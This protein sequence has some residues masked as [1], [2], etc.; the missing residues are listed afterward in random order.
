[1]IFSLLFSSPILHDNVHRNI[2]LYV[3]GSIMY[4][5]IHWI[6]FSSN[7]QK[8]GKYKYLLY[9]LVAC[10]I[11][12]LSRLLSKQKNNR[13]N[14]NIQQTQHTQLQPPQH[15]Q[16]QQTQPQQTQPQQTQPAQL[17][18]SQQ[19]I[20]LQPPQ[21]I[22]DNLSVA[23]I[24]VYVSHEH[25]PQQNRQPSQS[26]HEPLQQPSQSLQPPQEDPVQTTNEVIHVPC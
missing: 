20:P 26:S 19:H 10:D 12:Y 7:T 23:T 2:Y 1:M 8:I 18:P 13:T 16:P 9:V 24:P 11:A 14:N 4:S 15:T 22:N 17:Q 3:I 21:H 25:Y 6:L 5:I